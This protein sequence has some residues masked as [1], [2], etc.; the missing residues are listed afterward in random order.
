MV[1]VLTKV[2]TGNLLL[3]LLCLVCTTNQRSILFGYLHL[4]VQGHQE[5]SPPCS[6][7]S[8]VVPFVS[9]IPLV[10]TRNAEGPE[11][12]GSGIFIAEGVDG[13][14]DKGSGDTTMF[15]VETFL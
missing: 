12:C 10:S 6:G 8:G 3:L 9:E 1:P 5:S 15:N 7:A 4:L 2:L 13:A 11:V 14:R